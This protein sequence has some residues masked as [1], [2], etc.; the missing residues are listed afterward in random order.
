MSHEPKPKHKC[1]HKPKPKPE[2]KPKPKLKP[3]LRL[4]LILKTKL[5]MQ[6]FESKHSVFVKS[7][8]ILWYSLF[9]DPLYIQDGFVFKTK[10]MGFLLR[11]LIN[12]TLK[13]LDTR[14]FHEKYLKWL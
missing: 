10:S 8:R 6:L 2:P 4:K 12:S 7:L 13:C 9:A 3:K 11:K 14:M 1:K 5:D